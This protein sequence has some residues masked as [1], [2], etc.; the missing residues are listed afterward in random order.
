MRERI[1]VGLL[2]LSCW[3]TCPALAQGQSGHHWNPVDVTGS[4]YVDGMRPDQPPAFI[5]TSPNSRR[6]EGLFLT[7]E[8]GTT[9]AGRLDQGNRS[10][11]A[12]WNGRTVTAR[13][14]RDTL[15]WGES[16]WTRLRILGLYFD[17]ESGATLEIVPDERGF[18][19]LRPTDAGGPQ[20]GRGGRGPRPAPIRLLAEDVF[21]FQGQK[22]MLVQE[23]GRSGRLVWNDGRTWTGPIWLQGQWMFNGQYCE[24]RQEGRAVQFQNENGDVS[25]GLI[26]GPNQV[27]ANG[28]NLTGKLSPNRTHI[29]WRNPTNDVWE[30]IT[31]PGQ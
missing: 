13:L 17:D 7:N 28:W 23:R 6:G 1:F 26:N 31:L 20:R 22:A 21:S 3:F 4:W 9:G 10:L 25:E 8:Q 27:I 19:Y 16:R 18:L 30:R 2:L 5:G 12:T 11:T 14:N 29:R 24:I 15:D